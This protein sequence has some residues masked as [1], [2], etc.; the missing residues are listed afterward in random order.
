MAVHTFYNPDLV[1]QL[2]AC[3]ITRRRSVP[4]APTSGFVL[5]GRRNPAHPREAVTNVIAVQGHVRIT[6]PRQPPPGPATAPALLALPASVVAT[7]PQTALEL[8]EECARLRR[9]NQRLSDE[10]ARLRADVAR[11]TGG[12]IAPRQREQDLDD[13]ATRFS[14]LE[15]DL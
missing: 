15:L 14:L 11:L 12:P 3:G 4:G 1:G 13:A 5:E 10:V 7:E 9:D 8:V 2:E 6:G